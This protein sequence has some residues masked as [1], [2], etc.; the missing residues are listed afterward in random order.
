[1]YHFS[2]PMPFYK[3]QINKLININNKV[4][5]SQIN[6]LYFSLHTN[7]SGFTGFEQDRYDWNTVTDFN[8]WKPLIEHSLNNNFD[9]IYI[10]NSPRTQNCADDN[11][12]IMLDKLDNLIN[13]LR[14]LNIKKVRVCNPQLMGYL[15]KYY[16]DIEL[17]ISTSL[18]YKTIKE[19]SNLFNMF[20]NIKEFVPSWDLNKNFNFLKNIKL[21]YPNIKVELMVNEGCIPGCP[22]RYIHNHWN[23]IQPTKENYNFYYTCG[24]ITSTCGKTSNKNRPYYLTSTNII[25]PWEIK[26]YKKIGITNF[27]LVGRNSDEFQTGEYLKYYEYYLKGIDDIK[28]IENIPIRYFNHYITHDENLNYTV[29]EIK[30]Y[31][32]NIKH[33]INKGHL[34]AAICQAECNYCQKC[35]QKLE[36][37]IKQQEQIEKLRHIPICQYT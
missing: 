30:P 3:E 21:K 5:K 26:E 37:A 27:K 25:Y 24:Y 15:N 36:K 22:F 12:K 14:S 17:Y 19:Y 10:L 28:N 18:E 23:K 13:N 33:F 34:C 20:N 8:Y 9:F 35:A 2:T 11:L 29:K 32:P 6:T 31:L 4:Y 7:S 16:P 1:M